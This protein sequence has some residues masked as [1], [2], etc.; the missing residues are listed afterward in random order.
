MIAIAIWH[1]LATLPFIF[2]KLLNLINSFLSITVFLV[3]ITKRLLL[4][5]L[6][7]TIILRKE[8]TF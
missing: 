2:I 1:S 8:I 7:L 3:V 4:N 6:R 5:K